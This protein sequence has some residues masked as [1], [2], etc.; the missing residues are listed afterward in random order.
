M[1]EVKSEDLGIVLVHEHIAAFPRDYD[2][3]PNPEFDEE[4]A[5]NRVAEEFLALKAY[6]VNT[7]MDA[8]PP[9]FGRNMKYAIQLAEESGLNIILST[10]LFL[11]SAMP[12]DTMDKETDELAYAM[13]NELVAG[14]GQTN[15]KAGII[16]V[17]VSNNNIAAFEVKALR[18]A[19]RAHRA[20]GTPIITHTEPG[21]S[22]GREQMDIFEDEGVAPSK[23]VIGHSCCCPDLEYHLDLLH[24]GVSVGFDRIGLE[25]PDY[26]G[27]DVRLAA[28]AGLI[29]AGYGKQLL[30]SQDVV[31]I[32]PFPADFSLPQ[33]SYLYLF[34][35]FIP[36]L[37]RA[38][39]RQE[40]IN[41]ILV[42][43]PRRLFS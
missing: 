29:A 10:G 37:R 9:G 3:H 38:G 32:H 14:I 8:T 22:M 6:G 41:A 5:L 34:K 21:Q 15:V 26:V 2:L 35:D 28:I 4:G 13:E 16:K 40:T 31:G 18:A 43:N 23:I 36:R 19:A 12:A 7:I 42:E 27:D 1:G 33:R 39:V 11:E 24:R 20:T 30:L 17:A 25:R